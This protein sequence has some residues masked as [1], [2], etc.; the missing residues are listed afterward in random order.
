KKGH[1]KSVCPEK[2][3]ENQELNKTETEVAD[4]VL[5]MHEVVFLN[6]EKVIPKT[7]DISKKE[8][9]VWYLDNGA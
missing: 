6:E 7:L 8:E 9:G 5:Y 3:E 2:K 4:V 1:F